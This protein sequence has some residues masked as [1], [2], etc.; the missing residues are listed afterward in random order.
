MS[1]VLQN[2]LPLNEVKPQEKAGTAVDCPFWD[3]EGV[4]NVSTHVPW[5]NLLATHHISREEIFLKEATMFSLVMDTHILENFG[6]DH[7]VKCMYTYVCT[8]IYILFP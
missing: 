2:R 1:C 5:Q 4:G 6:N 7:K 3:E 8:C